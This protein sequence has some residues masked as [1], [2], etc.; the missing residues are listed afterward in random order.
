M[1]G[2]ERRCHKFRRVAQKGMVD[3]VSSA[4]AT[5]LEIPVTIQGARPVEGT[6]RRELFTETTKT[7]LVFEN[8]AVV[9]LNSRVSLGQCVFLRNDESGREI[10]CKVLKW[11][12]VGQS[13]YTDL[14]F[15]ADDSAFWGVHAE[16]NS[17][18]GHK[19]DAHK[20][21]EAPRENPDTTPRMETGALTSGEMPATFLDTATTPLACP[22]PLT[23]EALPEPANELDSSDAKGAELLPALI[24]DDA[25]PKPEQEPPPPRTIEIERPAISAEVLV[26]RETNS[27]TASEAR[28]FPTQV[29][30]TPT[31]SKISAQK[32]P[33]AIGIA[34][35]VLLAAVLGGAWHVKRGSSIHKSDRPLA[36]SAQSRQPSLP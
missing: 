9:N 11:R 22:L 15:T 29:S 12:Q 26:S 2:P 28:E 23:T 20:A 16:Q 13:G 25:R 32:N 33:I 3:S 10:L 27:D 8:G 30:Q 17:A 6:A 35:S 5:P 31:T 1:L 7:T 36:A 14:E 21:I 18:A 4:Q 34:A 19:P 24:A